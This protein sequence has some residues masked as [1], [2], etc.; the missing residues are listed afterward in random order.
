MVDQINEIYTS[1]QQLQLQPTRHNIQLLGRC[2]DLLEQ[3]ARQIVE[4][5]DKP[6]SDEAGTT[7]ETE[8]AAED[9]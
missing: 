4:G 8:E 7:D 9:V 1:I 6:E 2:M 3:I 5:N